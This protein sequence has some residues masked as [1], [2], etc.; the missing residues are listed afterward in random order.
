MQN[1]V[2]TNLQYFPNSLCQLWDPRVREQ[3]LHGLHW[4]REEVSVAEWDWGRCYQSG[5]AEGGNDR[6]FHVVPASWIGLDWCRWFL[7]IYIHV[8]YSTSVTEST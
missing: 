7:R 6:E 3:F 8:T 4:G 2:R 5:E 1:H